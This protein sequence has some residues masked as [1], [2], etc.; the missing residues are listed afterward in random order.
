MEIG[1]ARVR[2]VD[3]K[4]C[5][6]F[7]QEEGFVVCA[8]ACVRAIVESL[9]AISGLVLRIAVAIDGHE[10]LSVQP[11]RIAIRA[12]ETSRFDIDRSMD[13]HDILQSEFFNAI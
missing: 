8:K 1:G 7:V 12:S 6:D 11:E 5:C 13:V 2:E 10:I 9:R 3:R 4:I